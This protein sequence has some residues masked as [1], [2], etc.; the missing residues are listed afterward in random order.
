[1]RPSPSALAAVSPALSP[2]DPRV[3]GGGSV[4][5][6]QSSA[7]QPRPSAH[8]PCGRASGP[9][10]AS[11]GC[12]VV[13]SVTSGP[14]P[15][16]SSTRTTRI[17]CL[18]VA[19]LP[20]RRW[21]TIVAHRDGRDWDHIT[22]RE[23]RA[24]GAAIRWVVSHPAAVNTRLLVIGDSVAALGALAKGRSSSLALRCILRP[25]TA[26][27]LAS[28]LSLRLAYIPSADNPADY[29]SRHPLTAW[30]PEAAAAF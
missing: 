9:P 22:A 14:Q 6:G 1:M 2:S 23:L 21:A 10:P 3:G 12:A 13:H 27:L 4:S 7:Q 25:I 28:G 30:R 8:T 11:S 15:V 5:G 19:A 16:L 29:A 26:L 17:H 24:V 18:S 20:R